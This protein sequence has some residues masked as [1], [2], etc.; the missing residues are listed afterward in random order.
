MRD[1]LLLLFQIFPLVMNSIAI[2]AGVILYFVLKRL[3]MK[4]YAVRNKN[5]L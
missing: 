4:R 5:T 2:F 3:R 1:E